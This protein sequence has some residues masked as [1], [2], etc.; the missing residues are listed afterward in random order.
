MYGFGVL[1][2]DVLGME[3]S[4]EE[5]MLKELFSSVSIAVV[6]CVIYADMGIEEK[7]K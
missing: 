3:I 5:A 6:R 4:A 1:E 7:V 2:I